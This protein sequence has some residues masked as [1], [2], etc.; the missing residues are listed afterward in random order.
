MSGDQWRPAWNQSAVYFELGD[1]RMTAETTKSV[2]ENR[3]GLEEADRQKVLAR[4]VKAL[5]FARLYTEAKQHVAALNEG[6]NRFSLQ[7]LIK[8]GLATRELATS[9]TAHKSRIRGR[10]TRHSGPA[11]W[12]LAVWKA[13]KISYRY[14]EAQCDVG[15][16]QLDFAGRFF[17]PRAR[18]V[19]SRSRPFRSCSLL[20]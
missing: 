6:S 8:D 10:F 17:P 4:L 18:C 7:N 5:L 13:S 12:Q 15:R 20:A 11:A 19:R 1:Y 14:V 2:L 3:H 9:S 16:R